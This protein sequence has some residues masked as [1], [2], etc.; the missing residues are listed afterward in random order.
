MLLVNT[1]EEF[2][3]AVQTNWKNMSAKWNYGGNYSPYTRLSG[4]L[5]M[6]DESSKP[7]VL[8]NIAR[9][10][11]VAQIMNFYTVMAGG[12]G[13]SAAFD[14]FATTRIPNLSDNRALMFVVYYGLIMSW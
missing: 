6:G 11:R 1:Y 5:W 8:V 14:E 13:I 4:G 3:H 9:P 12:V 2:S 7:A 10:S